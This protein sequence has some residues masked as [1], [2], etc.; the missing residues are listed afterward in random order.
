MLYISIHQDPSTIFPGKGFIEEIGKGV[1][2]GYN[3]NIPMPPGSENSDYILMLNGILEPLLVS[4]E[5]IFTW[6]MLA[7]MATETPS[8]CIQLTDDFYP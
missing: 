2:E 8:S 6:L 5:R 3:L 1:G 7:L 4:L